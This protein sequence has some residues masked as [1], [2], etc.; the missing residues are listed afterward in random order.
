MSAT[1]TTEQGI[2]TMTRTIVSHLRDY[3]P[4]S[5]WDR[6]VRDYAIELVDNLQYLYADDFESPAVVERALLNGAQDWQ[7][8]S[9]GGCS[10]FYDQDIAERLCSPSELR[11]VT[12]KNGQ[13]RDMANSRENWI[14]VQA[15]ALDQAARLIMR[16][17][18]SINTNR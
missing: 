7:Q 2:E 3:R 13:I 17:V 8:Y 4:R 5:A 12:Y 14:D 10:L 15:R 16:T 1:I 6:G 9:E 18:R 11:R